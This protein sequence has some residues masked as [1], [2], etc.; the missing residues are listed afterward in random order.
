[1][2]LSLH[3]EVGASANIPTTHVADAGSEPSLVFSPQEGEPC[4]A[5]DDWLFITVSPRYS[6]LPRF[7]HGV[8]LIAKDNPAFCV[9]RGHDFKN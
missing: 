1:M 4:T 8:R 5:G 3:E 7:N 6:K 9:Q 2:R